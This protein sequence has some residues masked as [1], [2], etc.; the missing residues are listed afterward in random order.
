MG[1]LDMERRG[2]FCA[3][4]S[5]DPK[6]NLNHVFTSWING[7]GA[8]PRTWGKLLDSIEERGSSSLRQVGCQIQHCFLRK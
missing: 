2:D 3:S 1:V 8:G 4:L 7:N 6:E 5:K